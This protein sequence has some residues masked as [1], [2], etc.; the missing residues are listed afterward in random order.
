MRLWLLSAELK[1]VLYLSRPLASCQH[2]P[3]LWPS[4]D[5]APLSAQPGKGPPAYKWLIRGRTPGEEVTWAR[6]SC[7]SSFGGGIGSKLSGTCSLCLPKYILRGGKGTGQAEGQ[8]GGQGGRKSR[9]HWQAIPGFLIRGARGLR[10]WAPKE[11]GAPGE[12][13]APHGQICRAG[14]LGL[15]AC[16][17]LLWASVFSS[18]K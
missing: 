16:F 3:F 5:P 18:V 11:T 17:Q 4:P 10:L 13:T 14:R 6:E 15:E 1:R 12:L 2:R 8:Q 9:R 7:S